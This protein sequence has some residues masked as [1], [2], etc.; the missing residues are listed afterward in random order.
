[1]CTIIKGC[2]RVKPTGEN[3]YQRTILQWAVRWAAMLVTR[4]L[5]GKDGRT[6]QERNEADHVKVLKLNSERQCGTSPLTRIRTK[7]GGT[8]MG[9][10]SLAWNFKGV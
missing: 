7:Q 6:A 2:F 5:V 8:K 10:G 9:K 3:W 4:Y 1:M